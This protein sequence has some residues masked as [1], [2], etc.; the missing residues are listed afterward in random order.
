MKKILPALAL[1]LLSTFVHAGC[2][3]TSNMDRETRQVWL[4]HGGWKLDSDAQVESFERNCQLLKKHGLAIQVSANS[5]VLTN[6]SMGYA[7][8][9]LKDF[10]HN[11]YTA[12]YANFHTATNTYASNDK[13]EE[14]MSLAIVQSFVGWRYESL[15]NA[16]RSMLAVRRDVREAYKK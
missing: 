7:I 1:S 4:K 13:A 6:V 10:Q 11:I 3:L 15:E 8:V 2:T 12:D 9:M 14:L 5:E 16:V